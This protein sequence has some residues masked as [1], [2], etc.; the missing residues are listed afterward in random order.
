MNFKELEAATRKLARPAGRQVPV[1]HRHHH[2]WS[3][4]F[5]RR[6]FL[7]AS[8]GTAAGGLV[9]GAGLLQARGAQAADGYSDPRPLPAGS[10]ALGGKFR[11]FGPTPDGSFDAIDAE[12]VTIT[13]FNGSFGLAY[14]SGW[15]TRT[16]TSTGFKERMPFVDADLRFMSGSYRGVDNRVRQGAFALI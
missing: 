5:S 13:D 11:V 9:L 2:T 3:E 16:N 8:L 12:P 1:A 15:C 6:R 7:R 14:I 10:Q 4:A